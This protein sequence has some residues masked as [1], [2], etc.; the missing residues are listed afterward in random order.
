[1]RTTRGLRG[2][3]RGA[4]VVLD[5]PAFGRSAQR[6][7]AWVSDGIHHDGWLDHMSF[8]EG[9]P[10]LTHTI[11]YTIEGLLETAYVLPELEWVAEVAH[12]C[13]QGLHNA[14]TRDS[15]ARRGG[16]VVALFS[17]GWVPTARFSCVTGTAQLALCCARLQGLVD[18]PDLAAWGHQLLDC[19]KRS[20]PLSGPPGVHGGVPGSA[21]LW[22]A[23]GSFRY[24]NW[25]AK[26]LA[27]ALLE[28]VSGGLPRLRYG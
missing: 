4:S 2:R 11:A 25:A 12:R 18:S 21:P 24:L 20:Q 15:R 10:T 3:W 26:F 14:W 23:Y 17:D 16:D 1:M 22:G 5:E 28:R 8:T 9:R 6:S 13:C 19:A 27:D 7:V